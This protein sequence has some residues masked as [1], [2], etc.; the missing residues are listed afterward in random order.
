V[1]RRWTGTRLTERRTTGRTTTADDPGA[2]RPVL[3]QDRVRIL[4][5]LKKD[6][7]SFFERTAASFISRVGDQVGAIR[8]AVGAGDAVRLQSSAHQLKGSALNLGVPLVAAT[9]A[10]LEAL[11]DAGRTTGADGLL[12]EL[13]REVDRAVD[14]LK[15]ATAQ[16][17]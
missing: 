14:A 8:D 2:T 4:H 9:A 16:S 5:E 12:D 1:V 10:R 3:D 7:I 6:G 11:G 17:R 15:E 13:G